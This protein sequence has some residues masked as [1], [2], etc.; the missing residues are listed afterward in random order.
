MW[1]SLYFNQRLK[2]TFQLKRA[3]VSSLVMREF[4]TKE[5]LNTKKQLLLRISSSY[6]LGL[7]KNKK[8][9]FYEENFH[10]KAFVVLKLAKCFLYWNQQFFLSWLLYQFHVLF[11]AASMWDDSVLRCRLADAHVEFLKHRGLNF[12]KINKSK[13]V[14]VHFYRLRTIE[15]S[16][17]LNSSIVKLIK[18]TVSWEG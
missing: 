1:R 7:P 12:S 8:A 4:A 17:K 5:D 11:T 9:I 3:T 13:V 16:W 18:T 15:N 10:T 6:D 2:F 14:W